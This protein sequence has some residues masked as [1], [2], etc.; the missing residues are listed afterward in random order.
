MY[1]CMCIHICVY[2][3][4]SISTLNA[5]VP[6]YAHQ[7]GGTIIAKAISSSV[8]GPHYACVLVHF[9][10]VESEGIFRVPLPCNIKTYSVPATQTHHFVLQG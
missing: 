4:I 10:S 1:V 7:L 9:I 2:I 3:C 5:N 6:D 8:I